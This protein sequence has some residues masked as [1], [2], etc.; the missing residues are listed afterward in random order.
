MAISANDAL[1]GK[2][3]LSHILV[4][5]N[6]KEIESSSS[7][8]YKMMKKKD[9]DKIYNSDH[10]RIYLSTLHRS[11]PVCA[12]VLIVLDEFARNPTT[13]V[14]GGWGCEDEFQSDRYE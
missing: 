3:K 14:R 11:G 10:L 2:E 9:D 4:P 1:C 8:I 5:Y 12:Y 13:S 6:Y 7:K